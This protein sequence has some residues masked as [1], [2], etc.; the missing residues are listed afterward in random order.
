MR[1][2]TPSESTPSEHRGGW[3]D[4]NAL[5]SKANP[6][7]QRGNRVDLHTLPSNRTPVG[8]LGPSEERHAVSLKSQCVGWAL[9]RIA[10][11][12]R[13]VAKHTRGAIEGG[14]NRTAFG[15]SLCI[16]RWN[17]FIDRDLVGGAG[18]RARWAPLVIVF[19][20]PEPRPTRCMWCQVKCEDYRQESPEACRGL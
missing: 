19:G 3:S 16:A 1:I 13:S 15:L 20:L 10:G 6:P 18:P 7:G 12:P 5:A 17:H 14:P 9:I 8:Q 4:T 2:H 11:T